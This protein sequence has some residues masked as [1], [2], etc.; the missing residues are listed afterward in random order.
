M[1][2]FRD[3]WQASSMEVWHGEEEEEE[4]QRER[5][6]ATLGGLLSV[7]AWGGKGRA[8]LLFPEQPPPPPLPPPVD[9]VLVHH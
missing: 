4:G 1:T 7:R 2:A 9:A 8:G 3:G 6:P 5:D